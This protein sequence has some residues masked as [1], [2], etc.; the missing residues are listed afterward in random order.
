MSRAGRNSARRLSGEKF[1]ESGS[2]GELSEHQAR[3]ESG[4]RRETREGDRVRGRAP[5]Q[6]VVGAS[7]T[8]E[9]A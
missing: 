3:R 9:G 5:S 6:R 4:A 2:G 1:L 7:M 8:S